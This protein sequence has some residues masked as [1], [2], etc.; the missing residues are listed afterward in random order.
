MK[1]VAF[2]LQK[3]GVGKTTL[4]G[5]MAYDASFKGKTILIDCDPQGNASSWFLKQFEYE[6]ADVLTGKILIQ[7]AIVK[8]LF[9]NFDMLPTFGLDGGLKLYGETKLNDEPFVFCD[10]FDEL[11]NLGYDY[12]I[13]DLSPGIGR[14]EKLVLIACE[15]V[16]TPM[17]PEFFSLDGLDIFDHEIKCLKSSMKRAPIHDT[18]I[19]NAFDARINQH[20]VIAESAQQLKYTLVTIPVDPVFRKSQSKGVSPQEFGGIKPHTEEAIRSI[21]EILWR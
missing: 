4:S 12:L 14:L 1:R 16:V 8:D 6:L 21:G 11:E 18:I 2:H 7:D 19:L 5:T 3:G 13:A 17:T 20:R 10:L 15:T 9:P